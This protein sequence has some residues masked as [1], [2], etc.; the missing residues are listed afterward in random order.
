MNLNS[1][2]DRHQTVSDSAF[3]QLNKKD[4]CVIVQLQIFNMLNTCNFNIIHL[5]SNFS[6]VQLRKKIYRVKIY[7]KYAIA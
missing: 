2:Q 1:Y 7:L 3:K 4:F 5:F 6:R